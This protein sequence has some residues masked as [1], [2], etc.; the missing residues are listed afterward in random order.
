MR[1]RIDGTVLPVLHV[2]LGPGEVLLAETGQLSWMSGNMRLNTTTRAAGA[3]GFLGAFTRALGGG[4]LFMTEFS[5]EGG[6]GEVAFAA[7]V[8]GHILEVELGSG[9]PAY[10]VHRH[11]FLCATP[12]V[13]LGMAI[14]RSLGAGIFGGD[15]FRL[16]RVSGDG[17]AFVE[18]GGEMVVRD[19]AAGET[20]LV[21]PGH[22]GMFEE[23]VAFDITMMRGIRN[24]LFGGDGLFLASLTG[25]GRL[26]LQTMT[27]PNLAHALEPYLSRDGVA[28]GVEAGAGAGVAGTLIRSLLKGG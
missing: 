19:L 26:W 17:R 9:R 3:G 23:T 2:E 6:R 4:G 16:Q 12:G 14:Q 20:L 7:H 27:I 18:L 5:P 24:A 22:V 13:V 28:S 25:P 1:T 15:G 11:G 10:L 8:P 21:H